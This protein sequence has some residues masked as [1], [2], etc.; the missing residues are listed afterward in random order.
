MKAL[1]VV[2]TACA[3]LLALPACKRPSREPAPSPQVTRAGTSPTRLGGGSALHWS[4]ALLGGQSSSEADRP[5]PAHPGLRRA[6]AGG[7]AWF[8]GAVDEAFSR[9]DPDTVGGDATPPC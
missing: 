3:M 7:I 6:E 4:G 8:Q 1:C 5:G 9:S 2:V